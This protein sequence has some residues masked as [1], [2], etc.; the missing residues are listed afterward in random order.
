MGLLLKKAPYFP[1]QSDY[2]ERDLHTNKLKYN[3]Q[4]GSQQAPT[5]SK[6]KPDSYFWLK[7]GNTLHN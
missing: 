2:A 3:K 7:R 4:R 5:P 1:I 6:Q